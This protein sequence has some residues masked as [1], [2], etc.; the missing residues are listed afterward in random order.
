MCHSGFTTVDFLPTAKAF[1]K[2]EEAA[3]AFTDR[4]ALLIFSVKLG[5]ND[6][7]IECRMAH[8]FRLQISNT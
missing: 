7:A 5:T 4:Q 6:S 1:N 3:H 8:R 2:V